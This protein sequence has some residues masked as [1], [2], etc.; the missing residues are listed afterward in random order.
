[1]RS[2]V[3]PL[4]NWSIQAPSKR[5]TFVVGTTKGELDHGGNGERAQSSQDPQK[6]GS[7]LNAL[8]RRILQDFL[9]PIHHSR[10]SKILDDAAVID[11]RHSDIPC[12]MIQQRLGVDENGKER[13]EQRQFQR[14][15]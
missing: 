6:T 7:E 11:G 4:N 2:H 8:S 1:M 14:S 9:Q 12:R 10:G 15:S 3:A 13:C 5:H